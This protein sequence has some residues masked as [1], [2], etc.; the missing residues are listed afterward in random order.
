M[1]QRGRKTPETLA[2]LAIESVEP[3][4]RLTP[5]DCLGAREVVEWQAIVERFGAQ[6][7]PRETHALLAS[8]CG[9]IVN[10][11]DVNLELS[12]LP[13]G[14]P[15]DLLGWNKFRKA[16]CSIFKEDKGRDGLHD[17]NDEVDWEAKCSDCLCCS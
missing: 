8:M 4:P 9:A 6:M 10:L 15:G 7:F 16:L 14:I 5:P 12:V 1:R 3:K 11:H 13:P 17:S 2:A